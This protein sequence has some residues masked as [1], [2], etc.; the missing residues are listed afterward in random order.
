MKVKPKLVK[1]ADV[2]PFVPPAHKDTYSWG[3]ISKETVGVDNVV[4][5]I[6][7]IK[8]GGCALNAIH[9]DSQQITYT[10]S[11]RGK[12]IAGGKEFMTEPGSCHFTPENTNHSTEAIGK[13]TLRQIIVLVKVHK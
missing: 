1:M 10:I 13:E 9:E 4:F 3:L 12:I 6:S 8:P 2:E 11:G 5:A 7:E